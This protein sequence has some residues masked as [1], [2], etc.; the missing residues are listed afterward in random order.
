MEAMWSLVM[1]IVLL[2]ILYG[3]LAVLINITLVYMF[4]ELYLEN[5]LWKLPLIIFWPITIPFA[6]CCAGFDWFKKYIDDTRRYY[7]LR[8][9]KKEKNK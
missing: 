8:R 3:V 2:G 7:L 4:Y 5:P 1:F 9:N 6:V